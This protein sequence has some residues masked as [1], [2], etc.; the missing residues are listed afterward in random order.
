MGKGTG[1]WR[2]GEE[3][4]DDDE[5]EL[6]EEYEKEEEEEEGGGD[7]G[8]EVRGEG[9]ESVRERRGAVWRSK[10]KHCEKK[11]CCRRGWGTGNS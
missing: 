4:E 6:D 2:K 11:H 10:R 8:M 7:G 3:E 1:G 5:E 9:S